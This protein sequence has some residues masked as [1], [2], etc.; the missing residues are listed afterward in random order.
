MGW[1]TRAGRGASAALIGPA[2]RTLAAIGAFHWM[3]D[4]QRLVNT[5]LTNLR[6][7]TDPMHIHAATIHSITPITITAGNVTTA[8]AALSYAGTLRVSIITDPHHGPEHARLEAALA[9]VLDQ[10]TGDPGPHSSVPSQ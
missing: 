2:F 10:L 7:P 1:I 5:F 4:R 8:F 9:S 6:G 3:I